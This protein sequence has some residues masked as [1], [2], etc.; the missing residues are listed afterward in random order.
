M[1]IR[2]KKAAA[3]VI[4]LALLIS[5]MPFGSSAA[6]NYDIYLLIGSDA[7][8]VG[9]TMYAYPVS[10]T[11]ADPDSLNFKYEW[12]LSDDGVSGFTTVHRSSE[13]TPAAGNQGKYV[14]LVMNEEK[15]GVT[16]ISSVLPI[17]DGANYTIRG[18]ADVSGNAKEGQTVTG[19]LNGIVGKTKDY[20]DELDNYITYWWEESENGKWFDIIP[21]SVGRVKMSFDSNDIGKYYRFVV[22]CTGG[23]MYMGTVFSS[24]MKVVSLKVGEDSALAA[25][26]GIEDIA[27]DITVSEG[28][29]TLAYDYGRS[30]LIVPDEG[31]VVSSITRNGEKLAI[32]DR[33]V[34]LDENDV[35]EIVFRQSDSALGIKHKYDEFTDISGHWAYD[36]ICYMVESGLASGTSAT[37][38]S[39]DERITRAMLVTML[40]RL[41]KATAGKSCPFGDVPAGSYYESYVTWANE[42]GIVTGDSASSFYPDRPLTRQELAAIIY[43]YAKYKEKSLKYSPEIFENYTDSSEIADWAVHAVGYCVENQIMNGRTASTI[44][45]EG[46]ATR[47]EVATILYRFL[48]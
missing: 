4:C 39:P 28:G 47:A 26:G 30:I 18:K 46:T 33:L 35:I 11:G 27:P 13:Y 10:I 45:P 9:L 37:T 6:L 43:R 48:R 40:G 32:S 14:R 44:E 29:K 36:A 1:K 19:K 15:N 20:T 16:V 41:E 25:A 21:G 42:K 8:R 7:P 23:D 34:N 24:S 5:L 31:Y 22:A 2:G 3:F 17:M 12:Q 38:F